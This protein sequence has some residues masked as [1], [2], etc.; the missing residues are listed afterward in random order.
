MT[1]CQS[2]LKKKKALLKLPLPEQI[3]TLLLTVILPAGFPADSLSGRRHRLRY[4]HPADQQDP[5][6]VPGSDHEHLQRHAL[7][8]GI[9][10]KTREGGILL[11][12]VFF[13]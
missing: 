3:L 6:G 13:L 7:T 9:K 10:E 5:G 2:P 1:C 8:Q 4:G 11:L 12:L